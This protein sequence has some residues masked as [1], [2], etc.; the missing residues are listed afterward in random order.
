MK[1]TSTSYEFFNFFILNKWKR[2][3]C[4]NLH[5]QA[6]NNKFEYCMDIIYSPIQINAKESWDL[7]IP[8]P[9]GA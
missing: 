3:G 4:Y 1:T 5:S 2:F 9:T 6:S 8:L 7:P